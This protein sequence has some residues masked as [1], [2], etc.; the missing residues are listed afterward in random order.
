MDVM[1]LCSLSC[2]IMDGANSA[3]TTC[4]TNLDADFAS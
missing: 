1:S 2:C 4:Q 3:A